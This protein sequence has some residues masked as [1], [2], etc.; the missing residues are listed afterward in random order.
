MCTNVR[1]PTGP[2]SPPAKKPAYRRAGRGRVWPRCSRDL[3]GRVA[4][5]PPA[6]ATPS[7]AG[8]P[9]SPRPPR[10]R[11]RRPAQ[12]TAPDQN[13]QR[14]G[15]APPAEASHR[16]L[17]TARRLLSR[18]RQPL[19]AGSV[20]T[21]PR[22]SGAPSDHPPAPRRRRSRRRGRRRSRATLAAPRRVGVGRDRRVRGRG[23]LTPP[24]VCVVCGESVQLQPRVGRLCQ[25]AE[26]ELR[27]GRTLAESSPR[28]GQE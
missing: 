23:Q 28:R 13:Q 20:L 5:G 21:I 9:R 4:R 6:R 7:T 16:P 11:E 27:S 24:A 26:I 3:A 14:N 25:R 22:R 19:R 1:A 2:I 18:R 8:A 17:T 12:H 10:R 15:W